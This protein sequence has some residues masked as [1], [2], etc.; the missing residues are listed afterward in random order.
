MDR[1]SE[2]KLGMGD[3]IKADIGTARRR[4]AL[5]CNAYAHLPRFCAYLTSL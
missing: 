4:A 5:S 1:L 2:F 3:E